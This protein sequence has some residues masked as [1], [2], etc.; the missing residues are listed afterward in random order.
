MKYA[1]IAFAL[2]T[3]SPAFAAMP[4]EQ[5]YKFEL[6]QC[7]LAPNAKQCAIKLAKCERVTQDKILKQN[8]DANLGMSITYSCL[9]RMGIA[10]PG[11]D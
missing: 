9:E 6:G 3:A 4:F 2:L 5:E 1:A 8:P 7:S 11:V 10:I